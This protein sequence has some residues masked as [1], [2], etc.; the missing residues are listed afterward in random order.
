MVVAWR[1]SGEVELTSRLLLN[2]I[3]LTTLPPTLLLPPPSPPLR[4]PPPPPLLAQLLAAAAARRRHSPPSLA[5]VDRPARHRGAS[6]ATLAY[7][8]SCSVLRPTAVLR[9][10]VLLST[11][12]AHCLRYM[13]TTTVY[14]YHAMRVAAL[15]RRVRVAI[16]VITPTRQG[17]FA[18]RPL[19]DLEPRA[20]RR[21]GTL[22][23]TRGV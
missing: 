3:E 17:C 22:G 2:D 11:S 14:H 12:L 16:S 20:S 18:M 21:R 1:S 15:L 7:Y 10:T 5:A 19:L 8:C 6:D 4:P 9:T 13:P 23:L